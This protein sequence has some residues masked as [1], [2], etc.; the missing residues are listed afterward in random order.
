MTVAPVVVI[1]D[2]VSKKASVKL[3]PGAP[4]ISGRV[5]KPVKAIQV[6]LVS[7][8]P[9]LS[10]RSPCLLSRHAKTS[11]AAAVSVTSIDRPNAP[12][13]ALPSR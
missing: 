10:V 8:K 13:F 9:C 2:I 5:P 12:A 11:A 3:R 4:S 6:E 7:R 1:A